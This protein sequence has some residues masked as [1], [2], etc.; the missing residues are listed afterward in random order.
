MI[1]LGSIVDDVK[2]ALSRGDAEIHKIWDE[3]MP[4]L[5]KA[6][7][8]GSRLAASPIAGAVEQILGLPPVAHDTIAKVLQIL[9]DDLGKL[10]PQPEPAPAADVPPAEGEQGVPA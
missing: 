8:L 5:E 9:A 4:A 1:N 2:G 7:E 10:V 6:A 3:S